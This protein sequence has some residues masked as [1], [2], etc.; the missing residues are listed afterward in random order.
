MGL[1]VNC[2]WCFE[3][4]WRN[5]NAGSNAMWRSNRERKPHNMLNTSLSSPAPA[6]ASAYEFTRAGGYALPSYPF[7]EPPELKT[8]EAMRYPVVVVGGGLAGLT[9]ACALAQLG[10]ASVVLEAGN[11]VGGPGA[12][13]RAMCYSQKS[14]EIFQ[15]LGIFE[16]VAAKGVQW[17]IGRTFAGK[18]EIYSF[19]QRQ[20]N[21]AN[22]SAQPVFTNIQQ[23]YVEGYLVERLPPWA[24]RQ[25]DGNHGWWLTSRAM[26]LPVSRYRPPPAATGC[27]PIM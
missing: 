17:R 12:S 26:G 6:F 2:H 3:I 5:I 14:L 16:R 10:V 9:M 25:C 18:D 20:Q 8:A 13:S 15:R 22:L 1:T 23:F 11:S 24:M 21:S 19:D 27:K 7:T 4:S